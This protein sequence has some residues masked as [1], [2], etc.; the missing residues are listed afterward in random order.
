MIAIKGGM[1]L[2]DRSSQLG[3]DGGS[4]PSDRQG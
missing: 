3:R 2:L 1:E 4:V